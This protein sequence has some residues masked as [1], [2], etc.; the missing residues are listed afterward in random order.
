MKN[1]LDVHPLAAA[2][3]ANRLDRLADLIVTQGET[4]LSDVGVQI[5]PRAVST[6][7]LIGDMG[8]AS[9]AD[10]A[11]KLGQPHQVTT[12][13][14]ELLITDGIITRT[15]DPHD[16]RRKLLMLT[17]LG[18]TQHQALERRLRRACE[19]FDAL[20]QEVDCDLP[21]VL[22]RMAAALGERSLTERARAIEEHQSKQTEAVI[23]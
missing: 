9:T 10:I 17:A 22:D 11:D 20:C 19:V 18:K 12:Q 4:L 6:I 2:F 14:V 15:P 13:R 7:L 8:T 5:P 16:G 23:S 21:Q 3:L 1:H